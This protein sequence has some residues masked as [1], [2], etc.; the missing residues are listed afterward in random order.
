[1]KLVAGL[2]ALAVIVVVAL[3]LV[4]GRTKCNYYKDP[5]AGPYGDWDAYLAAGKPVLDAE[6]TQD[7]ET[8][9]RFCPVD[10]TWGIWGAL[11]S[12]EHNGDKTYRVCWNTKNRL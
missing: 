7:G 3:S 12:V 6:Y 1:M 9:A 10:R 11:Y 8:S 4:S 2:S 5:C